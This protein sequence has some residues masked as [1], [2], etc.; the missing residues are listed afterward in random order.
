MNLFDPDPLLVVNFEWT[1]QVK[2][3]PRFANGRVYTPTRTLKAEAAIEA[4]F[5]EAVGPW[6][7]YADTCAVDWILGND[8][9]TVTLTPWPDYTNRKLRGDVDNYQKILSDSL[10]GVLYDDDRRIV[11]TSAV[12]L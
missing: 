1:P 4:A 3:R 8:T 9:V 5:R 2:E 11:K 7:P 10:N 12:K 6:E